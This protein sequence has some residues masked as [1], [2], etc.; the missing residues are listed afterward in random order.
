MWEVM[1]HD[2]QRFGLGEEPMFEI[3]QPEPKLNL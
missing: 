3:R 2:R 1:Q